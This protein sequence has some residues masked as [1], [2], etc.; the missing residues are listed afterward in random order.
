ME[1]VRDNYMTVSEVADR[2]GK[3]TASIRNT[4]AAG[5]VAGA[6]KVG[7][8]WLIPRDRLDDGTFE[9]TISRRKDYSKKS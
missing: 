6:V 9:R 2:V 1:S 5:K 7:S 8:V 3:F 4:L